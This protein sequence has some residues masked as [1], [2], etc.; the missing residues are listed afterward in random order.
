MKKLIFILL[1]GLLIISSSGIAGCDQNR[2][3]TE[4]DIFFPVLEEPEAYYPSALS[5]GK[6]IFNGKYL[7]LKRNFLIFST[8]ILLI[9]PYGYSV[10]VENEEIH[11]L[12]ENGQA[13]ASVGDSIKVG[14][15]E[16]PASNVEKLI[17]YSLP[18]DWYGICWLVASIDLL[19]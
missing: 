5:E 16:N 17:G 4:S 18:D 3:I 14:G 13:V 10:D 15:G 8:K 19:K 12:N 9:W 7:L 6:L 2:D 1:S 11:I